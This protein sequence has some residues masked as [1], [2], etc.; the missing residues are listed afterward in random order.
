MREREREEG[1]RVF[2]QKFVAGVAFEADL[3]LAGRTVVY[4]IRGSKGTRSDNCSVLRF[5]NAV[6]MCER[7]FSRCFAGRRRRESHEAHVRRMT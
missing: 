5:V 4:T 1:G 3:S 6:Q 2:A 7:S